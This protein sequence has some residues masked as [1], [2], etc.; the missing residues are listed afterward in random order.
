MGPIPPS[1]LSGGVKTL[2]LIA[3]DP[4]H[5]FNASACGDNCAGWLLRLGKSRDILIRLGYLM[6]FGDD[7][8]EIQIENSGKIVRSDRELVHEVIRQGYLRENLV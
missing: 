4:A 5:I 3:N 8:L 6:E 7:P 2:I 1:R